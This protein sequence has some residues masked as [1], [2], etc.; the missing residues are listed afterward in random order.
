LQNS[1][2]Q[3]EAAFFYFARAINETILSVV[4]IQQGNPKEGIKHKIKSVHS[5][6]RDLEIS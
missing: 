3:L 1:N 5:G 4:A 6:Y 2:S